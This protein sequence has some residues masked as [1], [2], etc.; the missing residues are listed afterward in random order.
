MIDVNLLASRAS[1]KKYDSG[2]VITKEKDNC[3]ELFIL[4][5]GK[6]NIVKN[7][8]MPNEQ[9]VETVTPGNIFGIMNFFNEGVCQYTSVAV[10][11][12]TVATINKANY[13]SLAKKHNDLFIDLMKMLS[14]SVTKMQNE[15]RLANLEKQKMIKSYNIDEE[16]FYKSMLFPKGHDQYPVIRPEE[17]DNF[18]YPH[19]FSC[20][21]CGQSFDSVTTLSSK[22]ITKGELSCD[23][24]RNY[25]SFEPIWYEVVT[26]P[27]CYFSAFESGFDTSQR[28]KKEQFVEQLELIRKRLILDFNGPRTL[29]Q[30]FASYYL[31][32]ICSSGFESKKQIDSKLWLSLS[33]LYSDI[34]D[35]KMEKF[36][37]E[38]ALEYTNIYYSETELSPETTQVNLMILGTLAKKLQ[39]YNDAILYLSKAMSVRNGK[40]VYKRLIDLEMDEIRDRKK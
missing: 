32:L 19:S 12:T 28:L 10:E 29:D 23:M 14:D 35:L 38:K 18:L 22:L 11:N 4:L 16:H 13:I 39:N 25:Q 15:I 1:M 31:A 5:I 36:A 21:H 27:H 37:I 3:N 17:Y 20:P 9:I 24:R 2:S 34:K 40:S 26:C 33:W 8:N 7:Y 30:V 6:V